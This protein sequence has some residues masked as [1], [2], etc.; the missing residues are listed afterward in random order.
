MHTLLIILAIIAGVVAIGVLG[1]L[2]WLFLF[3]FDW[4]H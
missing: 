3:G 4:S 1:F 2:V